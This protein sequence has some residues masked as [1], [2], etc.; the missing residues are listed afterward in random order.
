LVPHNSPS[1]RERVTASSLLSP[2]I[3]VI[4][5]AQKKAGVEPLEGRSQDQL[6]EDSPQNKSGNK[7]SPPQQEAPP[8]KRKTQG[9]T[10]TQR[11]PGGTLNSNSG[12]GSGSDD[13]DDEEEE[14]EEQGGEEDAEAF[15]DEISTG[16][17]AKNDRGVHTSSESPSRR[18]PSKLDSQS[19]RSPLHQH[20]HPQDMPSTPT[21]LGLATAPQSAL[22]GTPSLF[23]PVRPQADLQS[24]Q[25]L[26]Q[27]QLSSSSTPDKDLQRENPVSSIASSYGLSEVSDT[28][29]HSAIVA[30]TWPLLPASKP[31]AMVAA[32]PKSSPFRP[33]PSDFDP[34]NSTLG[35]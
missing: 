30:S 2:W 14:R 23:S 26:G 6:T 21:Q 7:R 34:D 13:D 5:E 33:F 35:N 32:A 11:P 4:Q 1:A 24:S 29:T 15:E 12:T 22:H 19:P 18:S 25:D 27:P 31:G 20:R 8:K 9:T 28:F 16:E 10:L 3:E 17:E